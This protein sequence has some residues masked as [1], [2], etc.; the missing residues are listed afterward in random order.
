MIVSAEA[1]AVQGLICVH[2]FSDSERRIL[3]VDG[4][5][6]ALNELSVRVHARF[7][8]AGAKG[9]PIAV[10]S[11]TLLLDAEIERVR[12]FARFAVDRLRI[13]RPVGEV[14]IEHDLV[15]GWG[16][17]SSGAVFGA[18]TAALAAASD[19]PLS[20]EQGSAL[21][22]M[23][24]YSAAASFVGGVSVIRSGQSRKRDGPRALPLALDNLPEINV[25]VVPIAPDR[26]AGPKSSKA[27]HADVVHS[28]YYRT[29]KR[30]VR[31]AV[32]S[33][34]AS[35]A[36]GDLGSL[37]RI[38]E[39]YV[40]QNLAVMSTGRENLFPWTGG[41]VSCLH[42]LRALRRQVEL[43]FSVSINS[44]PSV[45]VYGSAQALEQVMSD[46]LTI[47]PTFL[48]DTP[49]ISGIGSGAT[50]SQRREP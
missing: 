37:A 34:E 28:P 23:G 16:V 10:V 29:W 20:S 24:S 33:A 18:L 8:K 1:K 3:P 39:E 4:I 2:G 7:D 48:I 43:P 22:R 36:R 19:Y 49:L 14:R 9:S 32:R 31:R 15:R 45:F 30:L 44:G 47:G 21:A 5:F 27:I 17:G 13:R 40:F 50:V 46:L 42:Y 38:S 12:R 35:I 25:M 11:N 6:A 26:N 41:T